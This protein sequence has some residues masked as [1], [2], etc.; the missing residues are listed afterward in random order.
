MVK[1][2]RLEQ[3][4]NFKNETTF[5]FCQGVNVFIGANGAGKTHLLKVIFALLK[6][7]EIT[8]TDRTG[9][10]E[11]RVANRLMDCFLPDEN[12]LSRLVSRSQGKQTCTIQ[13]QT[14]NFKETVSFVRGSGK[15]KNEIE[16]IMDRVDAPNTITTKAI[17]LPSREIISIFDGFL[18]LYNRRET[19]FDA[20]YYY[21]AESLAINKK[22]GAN[23][24]EAKVLRKIMD[25][26]FDKKTTVTKEGERFYLK[27]NQ[28]TMEMALV[29]E[30]MRKIAT[31]LYLIDNAELSANSVLFWDEPEANLNPK[32]T[33]LIAEL[34]LILSHQGVQIFVA[35]HDYL[36]TH[37]LSHFAEYSD[38]YKKE[39]KMKKM[40]EFRFFS[41]QKTEEE[42]TVE[43][44]NTIS[45]LQN[46]LILEEFALFYD[47]EQQYF[48]KSIA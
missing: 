24:L 16:P 34:L 20:T 22:K 47:L 43:T 8:K 44:A 4:T 29:S 6:A 7:E 46:N 42:L 28:G 31:L 37:H 39:R 3:F 36:L 25:D 45:G 40:P 2:I 9:T 1:S 27:S 5:D 26:F 14:T 33:Q 21:L 35:T 11:E 48:N 30:G 15:G 12:Q 17:F 23:T 18:A 10:K 38:I 13:I 41:L 19:N 32:L